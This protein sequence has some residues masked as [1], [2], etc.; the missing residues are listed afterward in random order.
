MIIKT[1]GTHLPVL[2]PP[3]GQ[4]D[5]TDEYIKA[6]LRSLPEAGPQILFATIFHIRKTL[7]FPAVQ[8]AEI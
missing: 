8:S 3:K 4:L 7:A 1:K 2:Y 5:H 6:T